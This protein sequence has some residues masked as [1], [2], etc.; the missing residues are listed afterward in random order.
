MS[1]S[2]Q[3]PA[4]DASGRGENVEWDAAKEMLVDAR[5]EFERIAGAL[6]HGTPAPQ[7]APAAEGISLYGGLSTH[8]HNGDVADI[9]REAMTDLVAQLNG[10]E[11]ATTGS[12]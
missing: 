9:A 11:E 7:R 4:R 3:K 8:K 2:D 12:P 10:E 1:T 6:A 5:Q